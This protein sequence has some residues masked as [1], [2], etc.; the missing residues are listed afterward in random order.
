MWRVVDIGGAQ[1]FLHAADN[2]LVIEKG[3]EKKA[4]IPFADIHSIVCHGLGCR[5]SDEFFKQ[6]MAHDI[7]VTFCDEK[8]VPVGMLLPVNQHTDFWDRQQVQIEATLPRKKDAWRQIVAEKLRNQGL[9]LQWIGNPKGLATLRML[10]E[11]VRSGDPDN[12][13]A[14][15]ARVYFSSL[16][17]EDFIR[18][19][20]DIIN[21]WLN[22]GY[23]IIRSAVARAVVGCGLLPSFGVFHSPKQNPF[24]LID[25]LME[26]LR[27]LVDFV[28]VKASSMGMQVDFTPKDK[29]ELMQLTQQ[30]V[31]FGA[32]RTILSDASAMY[33]MSYL[34]FLKRDTEEI[35][36]PNFREIFHARP[37]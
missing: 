17:G 24:C 32:E 10:A 22:Y 23:T 9:V 4:K 21:I 37:L 28:V 2:S 36:F 1:Y 31:F 33:V 15:G 29:K 13:E 5:Y 26:P 25:D 27:P 16:F 12:K 19:D 7:P 35:V 30:P 14:Q 3:D 8:H 18:R 6:S 11:R 20:D 34:R